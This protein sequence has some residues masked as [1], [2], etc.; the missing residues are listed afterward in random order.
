VTEMSERNMWYENRNSNPKDFIKRPERPRRLQRF[1]GLVAKTKDEETK[2]FLEDIT[3]KELN[4]K[5]RIKEG[6]VFIENPE[7]IE[8][9]LS[10][11][12]YCKRLA[13]EIQG[14]DKK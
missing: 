5:V 9:V 7:G 3:K 6:L 10:V 2:K 14:V 11:Y 12:E 8:E 4:K 13:N 1:L